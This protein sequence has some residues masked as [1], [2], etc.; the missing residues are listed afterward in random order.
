[1]IRFHG[2]KSVWPIIK[3][4]I[5]R[6]KKSHQIFAAIAYVGSDA[7]KIMP[8]RRGDILVCNASDAAIKQ[9]STSATALKSF[10]N[11]GVRIFNEPR[12]HGK[13][14]VFPKR[15]FIGSA[16]VSSRSRDV[17]LEAVIETSDPGI[18]VSSQRFVERHALAISRFNRDDIKRIQKIPVKKMSLPP[19]LVPPALMKVPRQVPLLKL[20][21]NEFDWYSKVVESEIR[22]QRKDI[23]HD[24]FDG[25]QMAHIEAEEWDSSW[26]DEFE[27]N[28]WY[29][30]VTKFGRIY[31]PRKIIRLS[32]VTK[33]K[34]IVW[35]AKPKE[36]KNF[37]KNPA[38]LSHLGFDWDAD[39]TVVLRK[40]RTE[41][42]LKLFR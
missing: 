31:K 8:L 6:S 42:L 4:Q 23:R 1:M 22:S 39:E 11:R 25:G 40:E 12:L 18:I 10:F 2:Q 28:M 17:L 19:Q 27:P 32:K 3:N 9:G 5:K 33:H 16:N 35:M 21:P 14:V 41:A 30:G 38:L 13:V 37:T 36:G 15:A 7:A 29:A 26:W 20:M 24:F 34:A